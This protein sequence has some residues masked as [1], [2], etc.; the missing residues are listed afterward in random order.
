MSKTLLLSEGAGRERRGIGLRNLPWR[1]TGSAHPGADVVVT[2]VA[3]RLFF[4]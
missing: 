2:F 4:I 1:M 3:E